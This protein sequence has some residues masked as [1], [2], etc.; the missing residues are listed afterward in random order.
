MKEKGSRYCNLSF[1]YETKLCIQY[2]SKRNDPK[3]QQRLI[4]H[5]QIHQLEIK[6]NLRKDKTNIYRSRACQKRRG[7]FLISI[8]SFDSLASFDKLM[9]RPT[10]LYQNFTVCV[11]VCVWVYALVSLSLS[12]HIYQHQKK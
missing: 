2:Y 10:P 7:R 12:T 6:R 9:W 3:S 11:G 5:T 8:Y 4:G 1:L